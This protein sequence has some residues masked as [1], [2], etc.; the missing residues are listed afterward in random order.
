MTD[1]I[2]REAAIAL[3][4]KIPIEQEGCPRDQALDAAVEALT[5]MPSAGSGW[6][7]IETAPKDGTLVILYS[8][9]E[10]AVC[11]GVFDHCLWHCAERHQ[12]DNGEFGFD[13]FEDATPSHWMPLPEFPA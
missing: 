13:G 2:S 5:N 9:A 11:V 8:P 4:N 1:L 12:P 7:P 3:L 10:E 6:R